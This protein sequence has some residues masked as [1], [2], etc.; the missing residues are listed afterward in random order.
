VAF[1][2][3]PAAEKFREMQPGILEQARAVRTAPWVGQRLDLV[4]YSGRQKREL[5]MRGVTGYLDLP[6]GPGQLWPLL[7]A[8]QWLHIGKGTVAGMGQVMIEASE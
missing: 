1:L 5:E 4:R 7:A 8:S 3:S 6:D 2:P